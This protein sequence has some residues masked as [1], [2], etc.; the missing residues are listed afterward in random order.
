[1]AHGHPSIP[2]PTYQRL[3]MKLNLLSTT[4]VDIKSTGRLQHHMERCLDGNLGGHGEV[5]QVLRRTLIGGLR[6]APLE[7]AES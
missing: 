2:S 6:Y 5:P 1:M 3:G 7:T 4:V